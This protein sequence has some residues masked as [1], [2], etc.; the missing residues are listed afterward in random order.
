MSDQPWLD[1]HLLLYFL[2]SGKHSGVA[3]DDKI[4]Y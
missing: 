4:K 1:A 3:K 2:L